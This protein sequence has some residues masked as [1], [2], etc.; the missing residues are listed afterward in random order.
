M[1]KA[2]I[3]VLVLS[4]AVSLGCGGA[5][6]GTLKTITLSATPSTNLQGTGGTV[7]LHAI[8]VYST[9]DTRDL[10]TKVTYTVTP[11]GSDD[12]GAPLLAPPSTM[13]LN[14]TGLATAVQPFVCTWVDTSGGASQPAWA[15]SGSYQVVATFKGITS[16]PVFISVASAASSTSASGQCG[17]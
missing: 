7:Q 6:I 12:T 13:T 11:T 8:G 10:T 3:A 2:L 1:R 15:V 16:Q 5:A 14:V 4:L 17:P 9:S